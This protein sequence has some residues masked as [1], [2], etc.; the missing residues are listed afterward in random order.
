MALIGMIIV[1]LSPH[2]I[3]FQPRLIEIPI[4][5]INLDNLGRMVKG[6]T[7]DITKGKTKISIKIKGTNGIVK[8]LTHRGSI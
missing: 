5:P 8:I 3:C 7:R 1:E 2:Q 6:S 4:K